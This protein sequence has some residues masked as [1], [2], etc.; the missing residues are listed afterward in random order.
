[1][2]LTEIKMRIHQ[3]HRWPLIPPLP[4]SEKSVVQDE[5][6][7]QEVLQRL[8]GHAL[9]LSAH[10]EY[11]KAALSQRWQVEGQDKVRTFVCA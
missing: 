8:P 6:H 4:S 10:S 3:I 7:E 1:M 5:Q 2:I 9:V 11:F